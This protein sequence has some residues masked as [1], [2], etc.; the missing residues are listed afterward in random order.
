MKEQA[1]LAIHRSS[2]NLHKWI[3]FLIISQN[4]TYSI[5]LSQKFGMQVGACSSSNLSGFKVCIIKI[6][7]WY[8]CANMFVIFCTFKF[9]YYKRWWDFRWSRWHNDIICNLKAFSNAESESSFIIKH[10]H[11][12]FQRDWDFNRL[13]MLFIPML[14]ICN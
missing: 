14:T 4:G 9:I 6:L 2:E 13:S 10:E 3:K 7:D 12:L 11:I 8:V 5:S 1:T